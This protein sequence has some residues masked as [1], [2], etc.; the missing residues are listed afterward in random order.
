LRQEAKLLAA[1]AVA[2]TLSGAPTMVD[3]DGLK[4]DGVSIRLWGIDAPEIGQPCHLGAD[5]GALARDALAALVTGRTV[6]CE[7]VNTDRYGRTV[8]RCER[9]GAVAAVVLQQRFRPASL[10]RAEL[11]DGGDLG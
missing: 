8:A 3:G 4:L 11:V 5:C 9:A 7:R 6:A 10:R 1:T 2:A